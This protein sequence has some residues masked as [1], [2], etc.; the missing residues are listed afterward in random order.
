MYLPG[1]FHLNDRNSPDTRWQN[2]QR[3]K[4]YRRDGRELHQP[5]LLVHTATRLV[6]RKERHVE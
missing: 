1:P 6:I 4:E 2:G 5:V 3:P